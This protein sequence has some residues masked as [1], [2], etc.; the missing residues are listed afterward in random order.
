M[1]APRKLRRKALSLKKIK[2]TTPEET[3]AMMPKLKVIKA[4]HA[5]RVL[6]LSR[7]RSALQP[8]CR[9]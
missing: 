9:R 5:T 7:Q 3:V 2:R 1:P 4:K 6:Q 8:V